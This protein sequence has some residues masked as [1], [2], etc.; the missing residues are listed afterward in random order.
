MMTGFYAWPITEL[1]LIISNQIF[2][3]PCTVAVWMLRDFFLCPNDACSFF[4][5][6]VVYLSMVKYTILE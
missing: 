6:N 3:K 4:C 1:Y 5:K 2:T